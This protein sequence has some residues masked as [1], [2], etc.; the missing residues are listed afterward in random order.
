MLRARVVHDPDPWF[1]GTGSM[2]PIDNVPDPASLALDAV[3]HTEWEKYLM[4]AALNESSSR[5]ACG[6]FPNV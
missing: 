1:D 3:W 6:S 4:D 5:S 2:N